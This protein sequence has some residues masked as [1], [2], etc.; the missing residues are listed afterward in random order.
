MTNNSTI[1]VMKSRTCTVAL[2]GDI[3]RHYRDRYVFVTPTIRA[4]IEHYIS[5]RL[6]RIGGS[7]WAA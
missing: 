2:G 4:A 3:R 1:S 5:L 6:F 7:I